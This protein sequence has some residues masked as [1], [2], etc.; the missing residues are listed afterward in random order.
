MVTPANL[1]PSSSSKLGHPAQVPAVARL[2]VFAN[3]R[4]V[5]NR[6]AEPQNPA[7]PHRPAGFCF[8]AVSWERAKPN[9]ATSTKIPGQSASALETRFRGGGQPSQQKS[10]I[11]DAHHRKSKICDAHHSSRSAKRHRLWILGS[12][13]YVVSIARMGR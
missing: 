6:W 7:G 1:P 13:H 8:V 3:Q 2:V 10:K 4:P 9:F 5:W 12:P 11:C